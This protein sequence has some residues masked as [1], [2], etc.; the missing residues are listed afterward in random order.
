MRWKCIVAFD[1]TDFF[2]W[3][4]QVGGNT[5][6]DYIERRLD[7][8]F[9]QPVRIM[10]SSRTDSGVHAA[11]LVFHFDAEW[12]HPVKHLLRAMRVGLPKGI[13]L[14]SV[15]HVPDSF[16]ARYSAAGKRY[17]YNIY[18]GWATPFEARYTYSLENRRLDIDKMKAAAAFIVGTHDFTAFAAERGDGST[19]DPVKEMR[20][21]DVVRRGQHVRIIFEGSGFLYKMARSISGALID[22]GV[23]KLEPDDLN[24][25]LQSRVRTALVVTAPAH[26][27]TLDK[28]FY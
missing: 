7:V 28:G 26:G 8:I 13:L 23:G 17:T 14:L 21:L 5:V 22:V 9:K 16:H 3:Q 1:G 24:A 20:R 10:G 18:E 19:E 12:S 11:G 27:L 6:Q 2:G 15:K 25:I 4:S